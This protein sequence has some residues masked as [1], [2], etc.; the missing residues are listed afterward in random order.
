MISII[1][2]GCICTLCIMCWFRHL[3]YYVFFLYLGYYVFVIWLE[4]GFWSSDFNIICSVANLV[5]CI[6][7]TSLYDDFVRHI[8]YDV[9]ILWPG[10][11]MFVLWLRAY[12]FV[13]HLGYYMF[14]LWHGY[15]ALDNHFGMEKSLKIPKR[16][17]ESVNRRTDNT[18]AKKGQKDKQRSTKHTHKTKD[19]VTGTPLKTEGERRCSG[20]VRSSCSTSGTRRIMYPPID[21]DILC[22]TATLVL[23]VLPL[24]WILCVGWPPWVLC[25]LPLTWIS[26]VLPLACVLCVGPPPWVL[27]V[28]P[29]AWVLCALP[30]RP[31]YY[32]FVL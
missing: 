24:T 11:Y 18:M 30:L 20:R 16:L 8:R 6:R 5:L 27:Y 4:Y 14:F 7:P 13:G 32:V 26:Y 22:W 28:M 2:Y 25:A 19:R 17:S 15:F 1:S 10:Y 12:I 31:G 9:P 21:L 23:C 29:L 3:G